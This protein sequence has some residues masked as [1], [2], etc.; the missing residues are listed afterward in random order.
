MMAGFYAI[1]IC[2]FLCGYALA[3]KIQPAE[4]NNFKESIIA[5]ESTAISILKT[6]HGAQATYNATEGNGNFGTLEQLIEK[7]LIPA[8]LAQ[9]V[10]CGYRFG[11]TRVELRSE[12]T[13]S[14][15]EVVAVPLKYG[16]TGRRSFYL[17]EWGVVRGADNKGFV[18]GKNDRPV[19][20]CGIYKFTEDCSVEFKDAIT[21]NE[22]EAIS[23]LRTIHRAQITYQST[24][25]AGNY[26]SLK[27]LAKTNMIN[28][29]LG[30]GLKCGY[31]FK[32]I[33]NEFVTNESPAS[34]G[35]IAIPF[36]YGKTGRTSFYIDESGVIRG[37]DKKGNPASV[38]DGQ[39]EK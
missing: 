5:N 39:M 20:D 38:R 34:F 31:R 27:Q 29:E 18:A 28:V 33:K 24:E 7:E 3:Q 35:L 32:I 21:I 9:G 13:Q 19:E 37:A 11:I 36:E 16:E 10:K 14:S 23:A 8:S 1:L 25:G 17:N 15:F 2:F 30:Q 6:I 26:G 12:K 4:S 22:K